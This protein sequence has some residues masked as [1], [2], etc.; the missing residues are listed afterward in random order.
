MY[1]RTANGQIEEVSIGDLRVEN[2]KTALPDKITPALAET[3]DLGLC[4]VPPVPPHADHQRVVRD[5]FVDDGRGGYRLLWRVEDKPVSEEMI[6]SE[7]A[8]RLRALAPEYTDE[9]RETWKNQVSEA[10]ALASDPDAP[11]PILRKLATA[12]GVPVTAFAAVVV[13]KD[14]ALADAAGD[15]LAAQRK[16]L[17]MDPWPADFAD[18]K[19]WPDFSKTDPS[20]VA[21]T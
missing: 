12:D 4:Q 11:A 8:Q 1:C 20:A 17:A 5:G 14:A 10:H 21:E 3:F 15:V 18:P 13:A 2:P 16:L 19:H 7:G 6:R 9:E